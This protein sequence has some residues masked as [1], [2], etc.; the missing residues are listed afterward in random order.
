MIVLLTFDYRYSLLMVTLQHC[1]TSF[2][3]ID[4]QGSPRTAYKNSGL[5]IHGRVPTGNIQQ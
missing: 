1:L 2:G 4:E 5:Y 3:S